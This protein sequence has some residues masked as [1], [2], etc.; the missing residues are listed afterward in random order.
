MKETKVLQLVQQATATE[1]KQYFADIM[2]KIQ[3]QADRTLL[4]VRTLKEA[5]ERAME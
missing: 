3:E 2:V 1:I 5:Q 4:Q